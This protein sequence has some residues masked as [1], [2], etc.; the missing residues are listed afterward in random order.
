MTKLIAKTAGQDV[1]P[2]AVGDLRAHEVD[3]GVITSISPYKGRDAA[4]SDALKAA[5]GMAFPA[6]NRATGKAK[7]R[8]VWCGQRQALL[9]GPE[10]DAALAE[11]AALTDQSDAWT[12]V[13]L[14][15]PGAQDALAR[16]MPLDLRDAHFKNGHTARSDLMHMSASL[17]RISTQG[18]Q[19]MVFRSLAQTLAH[20]LKVAMQGVAARAGV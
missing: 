11:F 7:A 8:A 10:P 18:W 20:D 4:L 16:L 6:P 9:M 3:P 17:T 2:I 1:F 15:G 12:V 19:I 5:H 14:D 13:R